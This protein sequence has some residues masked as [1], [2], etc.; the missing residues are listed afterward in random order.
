VGLNFMPAH[1][2]KKK[3][4]CLVKKKKQKTDKQSAKQKF[5]DDTLCKFITVGDPRVY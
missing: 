5:N 3:T 4:H 2:T 1:K